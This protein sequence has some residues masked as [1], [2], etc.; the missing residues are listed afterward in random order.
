[1]RARPHPRPLSGVLPKLGASS[2][3]SRRVHLSRVGPRAGPLRGTGRDGGT[4]PPRERGFLNHL[5]CSVLC[6]QQ[7]A[8]MPFQPRLCCVYEA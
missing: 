3:A 5:F 6:A 8:R 2:P 1:M 7:E 4:P